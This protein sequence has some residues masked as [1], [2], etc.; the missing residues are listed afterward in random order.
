MS[1]PVS[2]QPT[3]STRA[4]RR[5]LRDCATGLYQQFYYLGKDV[6]CREGNLL[7]EYGFTKAPSE[8]FKKTSCYTLEQPGFT[9]ELYGS[10]ASCVTPQ[11]QVVFL[12]PKNRFYHWVSPHRCIA[13]RWSAAD[14]D[15]GT[16]DSLYTAVRPL[17]QWWLTYEAW[18]RERMPPAYR[19][20]IHREWKK[21]N[22][23]KSWLT[24]NQDTDWV[25]SFLQQGHETPR[26]QLRSPR[27]P[28][29]SP[30]RYHAPHRRAS[31]PPL[32]L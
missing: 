18:L 24:P 23:R 26:P 22:R 4:L 9:L 21:Q 12:R 32:S 30:A 20:Q 8:G 19:Q 25:A 7:L 3:A 31:T 28:S 10:C 17:L 6:T 27:H 1:L 13:G 29:T 14:L 5:L 16:A 15:A 11:G 2:P